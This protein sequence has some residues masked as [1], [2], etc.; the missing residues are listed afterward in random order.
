MKEQRFKI[1]D[2]VT[3]KSR[4]KCI[5]SNGHK[6]I[7]FYGGDEHHG[8]VGTITNYNGYRDTEEC[9]S[10]DVTSK[11]H[12]TFSMLECEFEEYDHKPEYKSLVG[13][14]VRFIKD[15][16]SAKKGEIFLVTEDDPSL[17][18]MEATGYGSFDR[19]RL[20]NGDCELVP[21]LRNLEDIQAEC[22]R[23]YPI[24]C[25]VQPVGSG[26][27][28]TLENDF[29]TYHVNTE[30]HCV[31]AHHMSG[32]LYKEGE[33]AKL[34]E[35][36]KV[37]TKMQEIQEECKRRFP[38]GC[39]YSRRGFIKQDKL[40]LDSSTYRISGDTIY[41]HSG[42]GYLYADGNYSELMPAEAEPPFSGHAVTSW[43]TTLSGSSVTLGTTTLSGVQGFTGSTSPT[44]Y[45]MG[46]D[47]CRFYPGVD[48]YQPSYLRN[49]CA[50]IHLPIGI[51]HQEAIIT[52]RVRK[53]N[54]LII[55]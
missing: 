37:K 40:R 34:V 3:Y 9:Y 47:P 15:T 33:W 4:E 10:I 55:K 19:H 12:H 18:C 42:G 48:G 16:G 36:V 30:T 45:I 8:F 27:V 5:S 23:R 35:A 31:Y 54:K 41:A 38:I 32:C 22:K 14:W 2:Q 39:T 49:P 28:Y 44:G 7:Y 53:S 20:V 43:A 6:G 26:T 21:I 25:R 29:T 1:G 24:G 13:R 11:E 46:V 51:T 50:E 52:K 17:D